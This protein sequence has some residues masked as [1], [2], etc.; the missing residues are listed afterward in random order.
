MFNSNIPATSLLSIEGSNCLGAHTPKTP[1]ILNSVIAMTNPLDNFNFN[2]SN[3][4]SAA[5]TP[6]VTIRNF[7]GNPNGQSHSQDSSHS[8][9]SASPLDSPAGTATTPSVQQ[10]CSQLIKAGLKLSIQSKRKLSTCD[11]SSGSEQPNSKCSRRDEDCE[12]S[13]DEDSET[14]SAPKGLTPEDEDRR[15]R[16]RERNKIAATKCRM[17]KRER[18]QN[19]IKESEVLDTQNV[20]LKNQVRTLETDRRRLLEMLQAHA[21]SCVK[22][23]GCQLPSKLLQSPAYKYL[24]ELELDGVGNGNGN[25]GGNSSSSSE[26]TGTSSAANTPTSHQQQQQQQHLQQQQQQQQ[27]MQSI[28]SMSTFKFGSKSPAAMA[29]AVAAAQQQQQ[30]HQLQQQQLPNGYCKPSPSPQEFEHAGYLSSPTQEALCLPQQQQQSTM[31]PASSNSN[32]DNSSNNNNNNSNLVVSQQVSDYVPNCE[33]LSL[34]LGLSIAITTP[35]N[36]NSSRNSN[37]SSNNSNNNSN[38]NNGSNNNHSNSNGN[39]SNIV[40][41]STSNVVVI[42]PPATT[43]TSS[44]IEFVKNELVDSQSPY[45]TALSAERF[46]FE[47]SEGF[48]DTK[49]AVSVHPSSLNNMTSV[50]SL[51]VHSGSNHSN[52]SSCNNNNNNNHLLD[53]HNGLP[54]TG[55]GAIGGVGGGIIGGIMTPCYE[56]DQ[57]LLMKN[58]CYTNDLL[59]HLTDDA[60]DFVDLDTGAAAFITNGGCLA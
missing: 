26:A 35:T 32:A 4:C 41:S 2:A 8:S 6:L 54:H 9:C 18:T 58:S 60:A 40:S 53:F 45:T 5:S 14:K 47:P 37:T 27:H 13:S 1:E 42:P 24:P 50:A 38:N 20:E 29:A 44:A 52:N 10:T 56:E 28:P 34:G 48:P 15:R 25:G 51:A 57:L 7:C 3:S 31:N 39:T 55:I 46:L 49:H 16:R 36:T 12:E 33:G 21:P 22:R 59:S 23:G 30:H 19:L 11:S 17:K 43:P